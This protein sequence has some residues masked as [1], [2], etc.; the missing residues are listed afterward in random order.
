MVSSVL[1]RVVVVAL[2]Y[3]VTGWLGLQL[4]YAGSQ[5]TLVWLPTGVAVAALLRWGWGVWP[6]IFL[7]AFLVNWLVAPVFSVAAGIAVGNTLAPVATVAWLKRSQFDPSF[8]RG[9]HVATFIA[10]ACSG[11]LLSAFGGVFNLWRAGAV[12]PDAA[13]VAWVSWWMGDTMGVLLAAP[14][15]LSITQDNLAQ[16]RRDR[17]A[18]L[19]WSLVA[20]P[21]AWFAFMHQYEHT[22]SRSLPLA[23]LTLPLIAWAALRLGSTGAAVAGLSFSVVAAWGTGVGRGT[24]YLPDTHVGLF[25]LWSYMAVSVLTSLMITAM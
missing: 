16:L 21:V 24:F 4:P 25:L 20:A 18:W 23:F 7:G 22:S 19:L 5:I 2:A 3:A 9:E 8:Q 13:G 10:A 14:L 11:M 12:P 6:G 15:L 1:T 17:G